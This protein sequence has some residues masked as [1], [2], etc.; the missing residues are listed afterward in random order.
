[1][2]K[3]TFFDLSL[4]LISIFFDKIKLK[5]VFI[6]DCQVLRRNWAIK[7]VSHDLI[8]ILTYSDLL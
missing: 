2:S 5:G 1:M 6:R 7:H 3:F 8:T 4:N